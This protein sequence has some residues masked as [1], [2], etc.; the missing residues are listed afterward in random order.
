MIIANDNIICSANTLAEITVTLK[1]SA[2]NS[3]MVITTLVAQ[4]TRGKIIQLN[5]LNK[6]QS[7]TITTNII[8]EP[9]S[10]KSLSI[11]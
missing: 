9:K 10:N 3:P 6:N 1:L 4:H 8:N 2:A 11:I 7:K 5:C